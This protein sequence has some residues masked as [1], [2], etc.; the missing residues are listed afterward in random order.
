MENK[1]ENFCLDCC[2]GSSW[3]IKFC[4]KINEKMQSQIIK[5]PINKWNRKKLINLDCR[6]TVIPKLCVAKIIYCVANF[7]DLIFHSKL[8]KF[9]F[10]NCKN[11]PFPNCQNFHF[12]IVK[13]FLSKL[14]KFSFPNYQNFP[15]QTVKISLSKLLKFYFSN[16]Q[17]FLF[18]KPSK[19][20]FPKCQNFPFQKSMKKNSWCVVK[21]LILV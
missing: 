7:T 15:F 1:Y 8:S 3:W 14:S 16:C 20:F 4:R 17:N 6:S 21:I 2:Q 11:F 19:F 9:S 13:I 10:P 18:S 12:Q 5:K